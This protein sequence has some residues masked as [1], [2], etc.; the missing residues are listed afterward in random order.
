[1]NKP[2]ET[3]ANCRYFDANEKDEH[4]ECRRFPPVAHIDGDVADI[5]TWFGFPGSK[6][7]VWC[8]EWSAA[9]S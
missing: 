7:S 5:Y 2:A 6:S 4:G 9:L 3:C 1:M 8:G